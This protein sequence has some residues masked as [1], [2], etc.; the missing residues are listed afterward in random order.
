MLYGGCLFAFG[1]GVLVG[2]WLRSGFVCHLLGFGL[3]LLG[4][5]VLR[6]R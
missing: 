1:L 4:V 2:T 3:I 5:C 6:K